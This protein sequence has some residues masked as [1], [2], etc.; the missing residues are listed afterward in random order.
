M[1]LYNTIFGECPHAQ[2]LLSQRLRLRRHQLPRYRDCFL[3]ALPHSKHPHIVVFT[4]SGGMN[5][6]AYA[7]H[8][9]FTRAFSSGQLVQSLDGQPVPTPALFNSDLERRADFVCSRD[10]IMDKTYAWFFFQPIKP[11]PSYITD[12]P[13]AYRDPAAMWHDLYS[14]MGEPDWQHKHQNDPHVQAA[15]REGERILE[16]MRAQVDGGVR[17][18]VIDT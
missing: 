3:E 14:K 10:D 17:F 15:I 18:A 7:D 16:A 5:R 4:R 2:F 8:A 1:A 9:S 11:V 6:E 12:D 13:Q